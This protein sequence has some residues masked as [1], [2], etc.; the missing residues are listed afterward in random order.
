M[1]FSELTLFISTQM[2]QGATEAQLREV[3]MN[4]GGWTR[5]DL[6]K[7]F[8]NVFM[9]Q[10]TKSPFQE[11][12]SPVVFPP[13]SS[14]TGPSLAQQSNLTGVTTNDG[15]QGVSPVVEKGGVQN[16][17]NVASPEASL[18][19]NRTPSFVSQEARGGM[20]QSSGVADSVST[21]P[22]TVGGVA[23]GPARKR[24]VSPL[25]LVAGMV[26]VIAVGGGAVFAYL[27]LASRSGS[28]PYTEKNLLSG[29]L[30]KMT[31]VQTATY[32][33]SGSIAMEPREQDAKPFIITEKSVDVEYV[34]AYK[35]DVERLKHVTDLSYLL[36][37]ESTY[38]AVLADVYT[39][40][41]EG[42][43]DYF[44]N[45]DDSLPV[46]PLTD[47]PYRYQVTS[48]GAHYELTITFE[49]PDALTA[50]QKP[51]S[52]NATST[53]VVEK[54][55]TFTDESGSYFFLPSEP[56]KP[57]LV[58]LGDQIRMMP[59]EL[60]S[61]LSVQVTTDLR[62]TAKP[63]WEFAVDGAADMGDLNYKVAF[64][65][66]KVEEDYYLRIRNLP[67]IFLSML[68]LTK[69]TWMSVSPSEYKDAGEYN[70]VSSFVQEIP[71]VEDEYKKGREEAMMFLRNMV[72]FA[73]EE[74]LVRLHGKPELVESE[75]ASSPLYRYE[76]RINKEA[77]LPF[78]TKV[79]AEAN[80]TKSV[81]DSGLFNDTGLL[82]YLKSDEFNQVFDYVD[83][84]TTLVLY[85][86]AKGYLARVAYTMR[87]VPPDTAKQLLNRQ[88]KVTLTL[89]LS[90]INEPLRIEVP[91]GAVPIGQVI[92]DAQKNL[93][94]TSTS[95]VPTVLNNTANVLNAFLTAE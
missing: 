27:Q 62:D 72:M 51:F 86:D 91:A 90:D 92:K 82:A 95:M 24:G 94:Y 33:L 76:V 59:P 4:Q 85:V 2:Q 40:V 68:G 81:S 38:P 46:D 75:H 20:V 3:L 78:M 87:L 10:Q 64:D 69:N 61:S 23:G 14:L 84:N 55:V 18:L 42:E 65:A 73:E 32:R 25:L 74:H 16:A 41:V 70:F 21:T 52:F 93:D 6:D 17:F 5:E 60:T 88:A 7:A 79:V 49:T 77:I 8:A 29:L 66:R 50:I 12:V 37:F 13:I 28:A 56:P 71:K 48:G 15:Q 1:D 45:Q 19:P 39:Q 44:Y 63:N 80:K 54:T 35:R 11:V 83:H 36:S 58:E 30:A 67:G 57:F 9:Q 26:L 31:N 47:M 89:S 34:A 53:R 43:G 22:G